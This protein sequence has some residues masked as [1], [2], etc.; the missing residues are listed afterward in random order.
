[1]LAIVSGLLLPSGTST[2][3]FPQFTSTSTVER[4]IILQKTITNHLKHEKVFCSLIV[5][6]NV[7]MQILHWLTFIEYSQNILK[8]FAI[9]SQNIVNRQPVGYSTNQPLYGILLWGGLGISLGSKNFNFLAFLL[10]HTFLFLCLGISLGSH[11]LNFSPLKRKHF[12]FW[13]EWFVAA[14]EWLRR[15]GRGSARWLQGDFTLVPNHLDLGFSPL[16]LFSFAFLHCFS[17]VLLFS[18]VSL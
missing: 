4:G 8:I 11:F 18:T 16:F 2:G 3:I 10:V 5:R 13:Q 17:L 15:W 7:N 9:Y 6:N 14:A 1:M 12:H